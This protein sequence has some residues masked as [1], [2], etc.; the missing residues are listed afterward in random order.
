MKRIV[1]GITGA[2][3]MLY[4]KRLLDALQGKAEVYVVVSDIGRKVA[5]LE[6]ADLSGYPFI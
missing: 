6:G 2:S 1:V 4:A 3:G 5:T